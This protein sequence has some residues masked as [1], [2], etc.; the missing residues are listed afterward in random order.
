MLRHI[1]LEGRRATYSRIMSVQTALLVTAAVLVLAIGAGFFMRSHDGRT[2]SGGSLRM[3]AEDVPT[4][5]AAGA[6]LVQFST[7]FCARC[8]QARRMLRTIA[9]GHRDVAH[10][11]VDLT[12]RSDLTNRYRVLQT[13]TTFLVDATGAVISR[14]G[15]IPD[16]RQ[17]E[18]ALETIPALQEN[19]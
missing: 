6:T 11:E 18:A 13:P 4:G 12:R 1:G 16:R 3:R 14:W 19:R 9:D 7:E 5:L 10:V 15:G 17:V 2:R 8:P